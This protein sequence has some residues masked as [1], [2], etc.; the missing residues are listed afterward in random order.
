MLCLSRKVDERVRLRVRHPDGSH[1]D[2]WISVIAVSTRHGRV[3][4]GVEAPQ[5]VIICREEVIRE[6]EQSV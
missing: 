6:Q 4:L 1:T 5:S 3:R 2:A